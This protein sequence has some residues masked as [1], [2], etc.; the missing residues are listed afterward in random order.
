M[1]LLLEVE[2]ADADV[3]L[4]GADAALRRLGGGG[5]WLGN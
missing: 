1:L 3:K 5:R 2:D 4:R